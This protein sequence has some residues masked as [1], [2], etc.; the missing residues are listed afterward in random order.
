LFLQREGWVLA[1]K[2][3]KQRDVELKREREK[4]RGREG[5][6]SGTLTR[7]IAY[8][9][10]SAVWRA[11]ISPIH[12]HFFFLFRRPEA[13]SKLSRFHQSY[14][15]GKTPCPLARH[16]AP[17]RG[18]KANSG[19]HLSSR[20][21]TLSHL[22]L[23]LTTNLS[24]LERR[25]AFGASRGGAKSAGCVSATGDRKTPTN[26]K[27]KRRPCTYLS[28]THTHTHFLPFFIPSGHVL[29]RRV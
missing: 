20:S 1:I 17:Q 28:H 19:Q 24:V 5:E 2:T 16:T 23:I 10:Q 29:F 11:E 14:Q 4:E 26:G 21:R 3:I 27:R 12:G 13:A 15:E 8:P 9:Q 18:T 25:R 6:K 7:V 22:N